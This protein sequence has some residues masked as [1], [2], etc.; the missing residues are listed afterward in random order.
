MTRRKDLP[1]RALPKGYAA[2]KDLRCTLTPRKHLSFRW[3]RQADPQG[4]GLRWAVRNMT[5]GWR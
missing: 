5:K 3:V 4:A 2:I 1:L